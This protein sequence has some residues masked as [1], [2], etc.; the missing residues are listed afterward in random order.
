M[1]VRD[2]M[3]RSVVSVTSDT[4]VRK[5][6]ELLDHHS[7]SA[8]PVI[9]ES[10]RV[11]GVVSE[12]D[13]LVKEH[14]SY[15]VRL[16]LPFVAI[17]SDQELRR[18]TEGHVAGEVMSTPA[19][20]IDEDAELRVAARMMTLYGVRRLPVTRAGKLIGIVSRRDVLAV[21]RRPDEEI[22]KEILTAVLKGRI[23][24]DTGRVKIDVH[25]GV[26]TL[27]GVVDRLSTARLIGFHVDRLDGVTKVNDEVGFLLDDLV[28][29]ERAEAPA[30]GPIE[31]IL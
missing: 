9:D 19:I 7:V 21:F 10:G 5:I 14:R 31:Q 22:R 18:R 16:H 25:D 12:A 15:H 13:L 27:R 8:L 17:D 2:V 24:D 28:T 1:K 30:V 29:H 6:I 20:T 26:V 23:V 11:L 3:T 4:A